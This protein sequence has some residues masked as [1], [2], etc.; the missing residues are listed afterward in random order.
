MVNSNYNYYSV[1]MARNQRQRQEQQRAQQ[2]PQ[3][4]QQR[5]QPQQQQASTTRKVTTAASAAT[6]NTTPAHSYTSKDEMNFEYHYNPVA[7]ATAKKVA[8]KAAADK[9][10][11]TSQAQESVA[12]TSETHHTIPQ[13]GLYE[14]PPRNEVFYRQ[15]QQQYQAKKQKTQQEQQEQHQYQQPEAATTD[16][17]DAALG[18]MHEQEAP[19]YIKGPLVGFVEIQH[20]PYS[21]GMLDDPDMVQAGMKP[22]R[23]VLRHLAVA[24]HARNAGIGTRLVQA[25]ERHVQMHWQM[26]ELVLEVDDLWDEATESGTSSA[27]EFYRRKGYEVVYTDPES[28]LYDENTGEVVGQI[29]CRRDVMR[30]IFVEDGDGTTGTTKGNMHKSATAAAAAAT[31]SATETSIDALDVEYFPSYETDEE[32]VSHSIV[33]DDSDETVA[34]AETEL[35]TDPS[36]GPRKKPSAVQSDPEG[37][38]RSIFEP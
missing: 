30:K 14:E 32:N 12:A 3:Q 5:V 20:I 10:S 13:E 8:S 34:A 2:Q 22:H 36:D 4:Q 24:K 21:L 38:N 16:P 11:K 1:E 27:V 31:A 37:L 23:P 33:D 19:M 26:K 29:Q 18:T 35:I 28:K 15:Q 17:H 6:T 9:A 25:C 7:A